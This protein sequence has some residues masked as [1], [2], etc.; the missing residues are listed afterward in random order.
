MNNVGKTS[1][2]EAIFLLLGAN[3]PDLSLRINMFRG[4][5]QFTNNYETMWGWL[6]NNKKIDNIIELIAKKI[7]MKLNLKF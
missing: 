3:I 6:F 1:L 5:E 4:I 7:K 2:L